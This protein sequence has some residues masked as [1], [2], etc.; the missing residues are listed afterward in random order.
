[1]NK[2]LG[3]YLTT[4]LICF[5]AGLLLA[6]IDPEV[7][8]IMIPVFNL[9]LFSRLKKQLSQPWLYGILTITL[10]IA[11][12]VFLLQYNYLLNLRWSCIGNGL[13]DIQTATGFLSSTIL[14]STISWEIG[15]GLAHRKT[16]NT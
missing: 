10:S 8:F 12:V 11:T 15:F 16:V 13:S 6:G 7:S 1:M 3:I 4:G 2:R 14:Y 5:I 9:I